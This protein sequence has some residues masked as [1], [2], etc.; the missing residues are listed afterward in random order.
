MHDERLFAFVM[1]PFDPVFQDVYRLGIKEAAVSL[2]FRAE[3]LD[4]QIF[5]EGMMDRLYQQIEQA[6][7]IIA[8]MS[9]KNAN[10]F[11]EVGFAHAKDKLCILLTSNA[12]DIPFD[13]KHRRHIVYSSI[14]TLRERLRED[15]EWAK[16]EISHRRSELLHIEHTVRRISLEVGVYAVE[17]ALVVAADLFN[18][19]AQRDVVIHALYLYLSAD[20]WTLCQ[21]GRECPL[22]RSDEEG[23]SYKYLLTMS[24]ARLHKG[25][26]A[27]VRIDCKKLLASKWSG[28]PSPDELVCNEPFLLRLVTDVGTRDYR[29]E[30]AADFSKMKRVSSE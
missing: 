20:D 9:N 19:S 7:I 13:L 15:L 23:Y 27:Q 16:A 5:A 22:T 28:D 21:D 17:G 18:R 1:M 26:W 25:G 10:V 11:Y 8:D 2:G 30:V 12:S 3:R 4:E 6:D 29:L 24:S 14:S